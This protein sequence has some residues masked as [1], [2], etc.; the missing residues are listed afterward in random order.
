MADE[1][2]HT[3]ESQRLKRIIERHSAY[4]PSTVDNATLIEPK[5]RKFRWSSCFSF[6]TKFKKNKSQKIRAS[7]S[8]EELNPNDDYRTKTLHSESTVQGAN[9]FIYLFFVQCH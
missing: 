9:P 1:A 7:K 4:E 6:I 8:F 2:F 5:S 3:L